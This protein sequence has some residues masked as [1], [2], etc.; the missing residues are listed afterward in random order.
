MN[1]RLPQVS[2]LRSVC[3][4]P[5]A[6]RSSGRVWA[7]GEAA[8]CVRHGTAWAEVSQSERAGEHQRRSAAKGMGLGWGLERHE[9]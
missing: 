7:S 4:R 9:S 8:I 6:P 3:T 5:S 2:S 1:M